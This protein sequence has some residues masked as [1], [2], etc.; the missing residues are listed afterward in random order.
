[1]SAFDWLAPPA[2]L[3]LTGAAIHLWRA[4]LEVADASYAALAATLSA[5]EHARAARL[6]VAP[7]RRTLVVGR[8]FLRDVL[9]RYLHLP[10]QALQFIYNRYGKPELCQAQATGLQ[11]NVA[12]SGDLAL[13]ALAWGRP[14]GIDLERHH[15]VEA[16]DRLVERYFAPGERAAFGRVPPVQ[17][18]PAFFAVWT[19]KEAYLKAQGVGL[20]GALDQ[21]EV[22]LMPGEPPV[23]CQGAPGWCLLD[24][25]AGPGYSAALAVPG[26]IGEL[27]TWQW[28]PWAISASMETNAPTA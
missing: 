28:S 20:T 2:R 6:R 13:L 11:F 23:F 26:A 19:R 22:S 17:Q 27:A 7:K 18:L 4:P 25:E 15:A 3:N 9:G 24:V 16:V 8:A 14:V 10:P 12:H 5:D 21:F 1:M